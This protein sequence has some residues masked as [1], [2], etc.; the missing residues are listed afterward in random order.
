MQLQKSVELYQTKSA[1]VISS[2]SESDTE[3]KPPVKKEKVET[4]SS[5]EK[6]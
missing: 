4:E 2:G 1:I 6:L 3:I 5:K